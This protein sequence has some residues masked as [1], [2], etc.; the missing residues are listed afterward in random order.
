[1]FPTTTKIVHT[2]DSG[3]KPAAEVAPYFRVR[4][5]RSCGWVGCTIVTIGLPDLISTSLRK[6]GRIIASL[7]MGCCQQRVRVPCG[8]LP[9]T[10]VALEC[11]RGERNLPI[12]A[13]DEIWAR[14]TYQLDVAIAAWR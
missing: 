5:V 12:P 9:V 11:S 10:R 2:G 8:R 4:Y 7:Y 1:M 14:N 6:L 13:T 3:R